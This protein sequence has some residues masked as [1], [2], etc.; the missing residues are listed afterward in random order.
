MTFTPPSGTPLL[1]SLAL[2]YSRR[3]FADVCWVGAF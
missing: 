2:L 3:V 1:R